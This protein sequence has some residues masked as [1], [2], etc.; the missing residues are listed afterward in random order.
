MGKSLIKVYPEF[1]DAHCFYASCLADLHKKEVAEK[2]WEDA[3][4][5]N[6]HNLNAHYFYALFLF[7]NGETSKALFHLKE[8]LRIDGNDANSRYILASI[9]FQRRQYKESEKQFK[10]ICDAI[11][12]NVN[13]KLRQNQIMIY[14]KN[15]ADVLIQIGEKQGAVQK[16]TKSLYI[17]KALKAQYVKKYNLK[18]EANVYSVCRCKHFLSSPNDENVYDFLVAF[19]CDTREKLATCLSRCKELKSAFGE[20]EKCL[21]LCP[22]HIEAI[23]RFASILSNLKKYK[24]AEKYFKKCLEKSNQKHG[25]CFNNFGVM[26]L[27]VGKYDEAMHFFKKAQ[28]VLKHQPNALR[29]VQKNIDLCS[30]KKVESITNKEQ[31]DEKTKK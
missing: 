3:I 1:S 21:K 11:S 31:N 13:S 27:N 7:F 25:K 30:R 8:C 12:S 28:Y 16:Y 10:I 4:N 5:L 9:Y 15:Y 22:N 6:E 18:K 24:K 26:R 20:C 29:E 23:F 19:E 14:Y 2:H 17:L